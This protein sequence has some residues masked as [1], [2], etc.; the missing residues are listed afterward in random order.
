MELDVQ[1]QDV[2]EDGERHLA[3]G[4][5]RHGHERQR[6][7]LVGEPADR[8]AHAGDEDGL[9]GQCRR[10]RTLLTVIGT[11]ISVFVSSVRPVAS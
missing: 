4:V 6:A 9:P 10:L 7:A 2:A 8:L 5:L 3:P 1:R 11:L